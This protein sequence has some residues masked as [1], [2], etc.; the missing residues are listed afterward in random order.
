MSLIRDIVTGS[1]TCTTSDGAGPSNAAG[2][3]VNALL[4]G[5]S[6]TQESLRE[7]PYIQPGAVHGSFITPAA[8]AAA[9]ASHAQSFQVPFLGTSSSLSQDTSSANMFM[10]G[11]MHGGQAGAAQRGEWDS[12]FSGKALNELPASSGQLPNQIPDRTLGS[13][14]GMFQSG[15]ST[16]L[17][18]LFQAFVNVS[19]SSASSLAVLPALIL[20]PEDQAAA[21]AALSVV[22]R[23]RI[24][25]RCTILARH[26]FADR[27]PEFAD[28]QV[29]QL[30]STLHIYP[31]DLPAE[32]PHVHDPAWHSLWQQQG[33]S[34]HNQRGRPMM[35]ETSG[36]TRPWLSEDL[37]AGAHHLHH[38][39]IQQAWDSVCEGDIL[40]AKTGSPALSTGWAQ[41]F[42]G[43]GGGFMAPNM[44][45]GGAGGAPI[46]RR[47]VGH[48]P[49][50]VMGNHH[51]GWAQEFS[52]M[53][54]P[55]SIGHEGL[56]NLQQQ[57]DAPSFM[58]QASSLQ[59]G[60]KDQ[61]VQE[62]S[63]KSDA[64]GD[65]TSS[66]NADAWASEFSSSAV[67]NQELAASAA[68]KSIRPGDAM[69]STRALVDLL[70]KDA[71]PKMHNSKFLHFVSKL[72]RGELM[73]EDNKVVEM[74]Q[75]GNLSGTAVRGGPDEW[76]SEFS[77]HQMSAPSSS[78]WASE[79]NNHAANE[80]QAS[81]SIAAA[82]SWAHDFSTHHHHHLSASSAARGDWVDEFA[83][84][85]ADIKLE[86]SQEGMA[87]AMEQAWGESGGVGTWVDE[88][89]NGE[90]ATYEEW[91]KIYGKGDFE[92]IFQGLGE[93][94]LAATTLG[95]RRGE[96]V[97]SDNN[98]FLG[99]PDALAKGK[100]LF[101]RG[102]LTEAALALEAVVRSTPDHSE[103]WRLLGTVHAENDDDQ[104]AIA[105][106][107]KALNADPQGLDVLL[108]LGVSHTN[109]LDTGEAV[110]YL[111]RWMAAH[112][113]YSALAAE[114]G[115]P[116]DSSQALSH[117]IRLF[118]LAS[119]RHSEDAELHV[120]VG[121]LHHLGRN[122]GMAIEAFERALKLRPQD[123]SLWNKLGATLA[124]NSRSSEAVYAYQKALDLKP[125]YMRAWTNMGISLANMGEYDKSASF[126][127]RA[128]GLN[129]NATQVWGYL[130]TS[131]AC[132]GR[133]DAMPAVDARDIAVLS[134]TCPLQL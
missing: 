27:G 34:H 97:F 101:R 36:S 51:N 29:G 87:A 91:E 98:P 122:Y 38:P 43:T 73:F 113:R 32:L 126:Y 121:V 13:S 57:Q 109:E 103:A 107:V 102:V 39:H 28:L 68:E 63:G 47:V 54:F 130:R 69:Q 6:K 92:S 115:P 10:N 133:M 60:Q 119:E 20:P 95:H 123:Y 116:P 21:A 22:D 96:Y 5:C 75:E 111:G 31:M 17:S 94:G 100:D 74:K 58:R 120:A 33:M 93:G 15:P 9:A 134:K 112:S 79:F 16:S 55:S 110:G 71:N 89:N 25:D 18:R 11:I 76:A 42:A 72:S 19:R 118:N 86:G 114:A 53:N 40:R 88:F 127:V 26:M 23:C 82:G 104:Q 59:A 1:D 64:A 44:L 50:H 106:M 67:V 56:A 81:A 80:Q 7:V 66:E 35:M 37:A 52:G 78:A 4:G 14:S 70:S 128:L 65:Q 24:R 131:L 129:P 105:A 84:G 117:T 99:D 61:W 62:F 90:D 12:I 45:T 77:S 125:N 46:M 30:L 85:V 124:N 41:E 49:S 2:S 48:G 132:A 83:K 8:A 3:L 108:S